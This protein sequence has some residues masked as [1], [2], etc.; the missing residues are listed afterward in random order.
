MVGVRVLLRGHS[1]EK[2]P[3]FVEVFGRTH[4]VNVSSGTSRWIDMPFTREETIQA[5]K[6]FKINCEF[7]WW[8]SSTKSMRTLWTPQIYLPVGLLTSFK[9]IYIYIYIYIYIMIARVSAM[10][11]S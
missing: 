3:S 10:M 2:S 6:I 5:G 11:T 4:M 1:I 9:L 8:S 7:S